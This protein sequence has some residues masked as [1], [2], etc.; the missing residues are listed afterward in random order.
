MDE[1]A[2]LAL[3]ADV[4]PEAGDDAAYVDGQVLTI[5]MLHESTDFPPGTT[6]YTR[7]WRAVGASLSDVAAMGA[8]ASA[9]VAAYGVPEFDQT[10]LSSFFAGASDVCEAVDARYVGGDLDA[11]E[12][13]T[14]STAAMGWTDTPVYRSGAAPGEALCVTGTFGRSAAA[15]TAFEQG[16]QDAG[17]SL[18]QFT[19]RVATGTALADHATA[20]MDSS[21]GLARSLHQ[22]AAESACGF[23]L[24]GSA[25]P[26]DPAVEAAA[27][28]DSEAREMA[29]YFGED[30]ELVFTVPAGDV[31]AAESAAQVPV[32][33]VGEVT[34]GGLRLDG[35]P[36]PDH[37]YTHD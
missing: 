36:M 15:L 20:M 5:D 27:T 3:V 21:D 17:N 24:D 29:L 31:A 9:A 25:V 34:G 1:R 22:L 30:F 2:A 12:E 4:V 7:G 18:F 28:T 11:H 8:D 16:D 37:G 13:P 19:P 33:R 23:D 10:E 32:T 6:P 35:K 26:V 14:V